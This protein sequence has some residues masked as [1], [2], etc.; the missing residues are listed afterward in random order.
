MMWK[1]NDIAICERAKRKSLI[2][3][4]LRCYATPARFA[5]RG[6]LPNSICE[7]SYEPYQW[8]SKCDNGGIH[9]APAAAY[10]GTHIQPSMIANIEQHVAG[11]HGI[12]ASGCPRRRPLRGVTDSGNAMHRADPRPPSW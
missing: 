12:E 2:A 3:I 1:A 11:Y 4:Q 7:V 6:N 5:G 9:I 10:T 8:L